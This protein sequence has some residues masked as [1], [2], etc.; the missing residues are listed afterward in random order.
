MNFRTN[1]LFSLFIG[2]ICTLG[3]TSS[4][5]GGETSNSGQLKRIIILSNND[6]P[7]W[8]AMDRGMH[9]AADE[10]G[11]EA[12]GYRVVLDQGDG[13]DV[14]QIEK[15]NQYANQIDVAA[16]GVSPINPDSSGTIEAMRKLQ[17]QGI[18]LVTVDSDVDRQR[19][20]DARFAYMGTNNFV[21]GQELGKAARVITPAGSA[22][23]TFV[24]IKTVDN[25]VKRITGFAEGAGEKF[26]ERDS[27]GDGMDP[28]RAQ[29][30][31]VNALSNHPDLGMLVGIWAHN[32]DAIV[33]IV[34]QQD[35]RN[36]VKVLTMDASE[37]AL[38]HMQDG[39]IDAMVV[40]N[41]YQMGY[42]GVRLIRALLEED[43]QTVKQYYPSFDPTTGKFDEPDGDIFN[44]ELRIVAPDPSS[45]LTPAMFD[46]SMQFFYLKDFQVWLTERKLRSS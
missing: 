14:D 37:K 2:A 17:Q 19:F 3:C 10:F 38:R 35:V 46:G 8:T 39:M 7:W 5:Q 24:G 34:K 33:T 45:P 4:D 40:Q 13:T 29:Q 21:A 12:A 20:R 23:A 11:F 43:Y 31:V 6:D 42:E 27:L 15:L 28:D 44:S 9:D 36:R 26:S 1:T 22:Y 16:V 32:A 25:A 18:V 41:P 30:N